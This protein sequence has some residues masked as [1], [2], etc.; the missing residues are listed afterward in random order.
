MQPERERMSAVIKGISGNKSEM[1][2]RLVAAGYRQADVARFL[3]VRDQFVSNVVRRKA[4]RSTEAAGGGSQIPKESLLRTDLTMDSAGRIVVPAEFRR[5][6]EAREGDV[7][8]ATLSNG[9]LRL[10]TARMA[11]KR[12]QELARELI[13]GGESLAD[14]LIADRRREAARESDDD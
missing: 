7:L 12:A 8:I 10:T 5:A 2:R 1:I 6:M 13:P 14:S 9:E 3:K 4:S 11:I